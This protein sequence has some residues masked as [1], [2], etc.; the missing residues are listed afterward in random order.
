MVGTVLV[1]VVLAVVFPVVVM[2]S[3]GLVAALLGWS[4]KDDVETRCEGSELVAL[5]R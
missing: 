4:L 2:L 1:V 3:G 5:N